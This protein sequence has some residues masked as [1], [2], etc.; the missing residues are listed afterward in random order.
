MADVESSRRPQEQGAENVEDSD[1]DPKT[2]E[3]TVTQ[4][5]ISNTNQLL[6]RGLLLMMSRLSNEENG[7]TP[8]RHGL[9]SNLPEKVRLS[10]KYLRN[11]LLDLQVL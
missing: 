1:S 11:L 2:T 5:D 10:L 4:P 8:F 3:P 7:S 9:I 6:A